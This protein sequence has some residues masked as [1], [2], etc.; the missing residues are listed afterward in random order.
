MVPSTTTGT[1]CSVKTDGT[2]IVVTGKKVGTC[3]VKL[4]QAGNTTY[5]ALPTTVKT[6]AVKK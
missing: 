2:D 1:I 6:I 3:K 5:S 4:T